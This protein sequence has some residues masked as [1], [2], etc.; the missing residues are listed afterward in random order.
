MD[1]STF[2]KN[3]RIMKENLPLKYLDRVV[4]GIATYN[5][6]ARNAGKKI[7]HAG[8]N[9]FSGISVFSYTVFKNQPSYADKLIKYLK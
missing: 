2:D 7:Y 5:Q 8:K 4:M 9:D 3:I 6:N 1:L